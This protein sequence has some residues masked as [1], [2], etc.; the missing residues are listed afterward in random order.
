MSIIDRARLPLLALVVTAPALAA[1][2]GPTIQG[3]GRA[4]VVERSVE[5]FTAVAARDG[6]TVQVRVGLAAA[7]TVQGDDNLVEHVATEVR[8]ATLVVTTTPEDV[9]LA[10]T[11]PTLVTVDAPS[12]SAFEASGASTLLAQGVSGP[13]VRLTASGG[14]HVTLAGA[15]ENASLAVSGGGDLDA[16]RLRAV[17]VDL[18]ASDAST[19]AVCATGSLHV[20]LSG[21]SHA[22]VH[23]A[24][25]KV[26]SDLSGGSGFTAR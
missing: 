17:D 24:P 8:G 23:C 14:S 12:L 18:T 16:A 5:P 7:V 13:L 1:C 15:A 2:D 11:M 10:P 6:F 3:S 4:A 25:A 21:D 22:D 9:D 26:D 20:S 19:C